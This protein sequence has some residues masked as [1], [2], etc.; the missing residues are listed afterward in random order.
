MFKIK[1][2]Q[3]SRHDT[4]IKQIYVKIIIYIFV[5]LVSRK[6]ILGVVW[7]ACAYH[8]FFKKEHAHQ[9]KE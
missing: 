7:L 8:F 1:I 2:K 9:G 6:F 3:A 5:I 4:S